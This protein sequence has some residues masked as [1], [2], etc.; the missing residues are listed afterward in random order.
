M[1][2]RREVSF[3]LYVNDGLSP[4]SSKQISSNSNTLSPMIAMLLDSLWVIVNSIVIIRSQSF[5]LVAICYTKR[6]KR[7]Y[8]RVSFSYLFL[9]QEESL[10]II[11]CWI[12]IHD[13]SVS[14]RALAYCSSHRLLDVSNDDS[15]SFPSPWC[16]ASGSTREG[17]K[18]RRSAEGVTESTRS[19]DWEPSKRIWPDG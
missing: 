3:N 10:G 7:Q 8:S 2:D 15:T 11:A 4:L 9:W 12:R 13:E 14:T 16:S 18:T 1:P 5:V 17:N 19:A 6:E